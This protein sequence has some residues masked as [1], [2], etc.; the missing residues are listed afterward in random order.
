MKDLHDQVRILVAGDD[1]AT[2]NVYQQILSPLSFDLEL[3]QPESDVAGEITRALEAHQPFAVAFLDRRMPPDSDS[4]WRVEQLQAL[5]QYL[6]LVIIREASDKYS[7]ELIRR[8]PPAQNLVLLQKPAHPQTIIQLASVLGAKWRL[9]QDLRHMYDH[10]QEEQ[11]KQTRL[12]Q[13][14]RAVEIMQLG[15]TITDLEGTILY[16]NRAEADMHGY[17]PKELLGANVSLLVAPDFRT[18]PAL[19]Q[20]KEWRGLVRES[21]HLRKDGTTFPVNLMSEIV[22][23]PEGEPYAL[24]TSCEDITEWKHKEEELRRSEERYRTVLE[25]ALDPVIVYNVEGG[26]IYLNHAFSRV[27]GWTMQESQGQT[28]NFV[29][30]ESL[31][32]NRLMLAKIVR[33]E[34]LSGLETYRLTK[35]GRR[36][37]VSLS[38]T[39]FFDRDGSLLGSILTIQDITTRKRTEEEIKFLAYY[40]V[41]TGLPN[42]T[43]FYMRL[44]D[45]VV[46][47]QSR[48]GKRRLGAQEKW[49]LLFLD[50]DKF[51]DVNDTL[52]H[53]VGDE[54][55][56][57]VAARLQH[58]VRK[59]D[60]VFRLGGDE[61]TILL[62][63]LR[64]S[65][66]VAKVTQK[67]CEEIARPYYIRD[68]EIHIMV[69]IGI[70]LYP[71]DGED[72]ETLVKNADMAMYAAKK[73]GQGYRFFTEEMH[74]NTLE[75]IMLESSL[76][77]A[78]EHKQFLL[79]Y[80]PL[81]GDSQQII[82]M[83]ALLRWQ[84]PE[85][86]VLSPDQF[87]PLAEETGMI[88]PIG[89]WVLQTACEQAGIWRRIH[90]KTHFSV[91]VN[92]SARQFKDPELIDTIEQVLKTTGLPPD[93]LKLEVTESGILDNPD[94]AITKMKILRAKGIHFS[95]DD[96]GM[97]YSPLSY[98]KRF[99]IDTLKIDRTFVNDALTNS[100]DQEIIKTIISMARTLNMS[101]VAEGIETKEQ[102]DFLVHEGCHVMQ[103]YYFGRPV[104][105]EQFEELLHI[106]QQ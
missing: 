30:A 51:K 98:L 6:E 69:S 95:I 31:P 46:Q 45:G 38:G 33:G 106:H 71:D 78:L 3:C 75:R 9:H 86:G 88:I 56:K 84:H 55:L 99:P 41:L 42:R 32:E 60:Y 14:E 24:V 93:C 81:V 92:L 16:T 64:Q 77:N 76:R 49:A 90:G 21:V 58:S 22:Q 62:N 36:L 48:T 34:T 61:F 100:D 59:S 1:L 68:H 105:G 10:L 35:D 83:E 15:V 87:L 44:E 80:Q 63:H 103:G 82:G 85:L 74:R 91:A 79:H 101:T 18:P 11:E 94:Q 65:S 50:L 8:I 70:S 17:Q 20:L 97:G 4:V 57:L 104:P 13:L 25:A 47:S 37:E 29:P 72:V 102:Q 27:F 39:G 67:L 28:L 23:D 96:F 7:E 2:L 40:D 43:S 54:L 73:E 66:A 12:H 19:E 26:V 89:R 53:D 52:G 5:D